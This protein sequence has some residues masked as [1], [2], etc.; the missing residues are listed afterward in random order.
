M[1]RS[2][3]RVAWQTATLLRRDRIVWP[4]LLA[5]VMITGLALLA[6]TWAIDEHE[7]ILFDAGSF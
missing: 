5:G 3:Y 4:V 1:L 6:S 7:K 2:I